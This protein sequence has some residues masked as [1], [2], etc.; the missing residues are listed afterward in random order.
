VERRRRGG[1]EHVKC[2]GATS[3]SVRQRHVRVGP[4]ANGERMAQGSTRRAEC[5]GRSGLT[6]VFCS[7]IP[8]ARLAK[9]GAKRAG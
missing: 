4:R 6:S 8:V 2:L 7:P 5:A 3:E 1:E 9:S